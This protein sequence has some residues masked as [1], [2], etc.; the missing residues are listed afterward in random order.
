MGKSVIAFVRSAFIFAVA[1]VVCF[2]CKEDTGSGPDA[3][4]SALEEA[5]ALADQNPNLRCLIVCKDDQIVKEKYFRPGA[6]LSAHDVRSVTKSVMATLIG[7]AIDRGIIPSEDS[8]I[9]RYVRSLVD[10]LEP[11]K[12]G[13]TIRH[14]LTMTS[15]LEGNDI[16][17]VPEYNNWFSAPNQMEYTLGK[18]LIYPPG[19]VFGYNT[20][21]SHLTSVILT[22]AAGGSTLDFARQYLFEP[23][24][25]AVHSWGTDKQ[26]YYNGGAALALTPHEMLAIGQLYLKRGVYNGV[27]V[28]SESWIAKAS[29]SQTRT[30]NV[31]HFA[32]GYGYFWWVGNTGHHDYFFANGYGGQFIVV[33][34]GLGLIVVA[35]NEWSG[36]SGATANQQWESTLSLIMNR[37]VTLYE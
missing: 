6:A 16:P 13:I 11:A 26:Q 12:A 34:P 37:I 25:I 29:A 10:T 23:L 2:S 33:V 4:S 1:A 8:T 19:T 20:G 35:T 31:L 36:V 14:L 7:I 17:D 3:A 28:V 24:G 32:S 27:R 5:F 21:A 15:G 30:G 18:R 22:R 9:G